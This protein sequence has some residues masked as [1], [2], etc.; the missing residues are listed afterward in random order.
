MQ[1]ESQSYLEYNIPYWPIVVGFILLLLVG[2]V[3]M[4]FMRF[5][6]SVDNRLIEHTIKSESKSYIKDVVIP[7]GI[8]G[9]HFIDY[10]ILLTDKILI[11]G[12]EPA[13]GYIFGAENLEQWT[14][15]VNNKSLRFDNPLHKN[16]QYVQTL[17]TL[18]AGIPLMGRVVFTSKSSF[19]K[20]KPAGVVEIHTLAQELKTLSL[21]EEP[22]SD[23]LNEWLALKEVVRKHKTTYNKEAVH[24]T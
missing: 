15:V 18:V 7:D 22:S 16:V 2:V 6:G 3:V 17:E 21:G 13:E 9:Y 20:G 14:Q 8:Y 23:M 4:I 12:V 5:R 11:L 19:P 1:A 24:S 10:L